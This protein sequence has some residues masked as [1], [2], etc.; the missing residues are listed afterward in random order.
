[1]LIA[2]DASHPLVFHC[3]AGKDR[4]GIVAALVLC[5]LGVERDT[6]VADYCE[7]SASMELIVD[8]LRRHPEYGKEIDTVPPDRFRAD[9]AHI[10]RFL[11]DLGARFCRARGWLLGGGLREWARARREVGR[12]EP[13]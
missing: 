3:A 10:V 13:A 2:D 9:S 1:E 6:I 11:D 8:R 12:L 4:T 7:T 5:A